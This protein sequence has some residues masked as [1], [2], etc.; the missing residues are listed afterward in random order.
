M[1]EIGWNLEELVKEDVD[2]IK[3]VF[4]KSDEDEWKTGMERK[5]TLYIYRKQKKRPEEGRYFN[6]EKS[7]IIFRIRTNT[8]KLKYWERHAG[9]E[10]ACGLCG[11]DVE[12]LEHFMVWCAELQGIRNEILKLQRPLEEDVHEVLGAVI[13]EKS[14]EEIIYRMWKRRSEILMGES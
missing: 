7:M 13:F 1:E 4:R 12:D 5:S 6:D 9:G 2:R 14:Y 8:A 10:V 11:G 3:E